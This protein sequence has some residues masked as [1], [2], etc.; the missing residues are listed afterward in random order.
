M[1][2]KCVNPECANFNQPVEIYSATLYWNEE[3]Q[4][5]K[6]REAIC[7]KCNSEMV[8]ITPKIPIG[9]KNISIGEVASMT[10]EQR[11]NVLKKRSKEHFKKNIKERKD[12]LL[13]SAI[14]EMRNGKK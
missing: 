10:K 8:D 1:T 7:S 13:N 9:E 2:Y 12:N 3:K 11:V 14:S 5:M 4:S 6:C